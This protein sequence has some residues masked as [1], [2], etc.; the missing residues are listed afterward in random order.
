MVAAIGGLARRGILVRSGSILELAA[1]VDTVIFDKTG[2]VTEGQFEIIRIIAGT[3]PQ[4]AH[5]TR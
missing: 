2:T 3:H 5:P 4:S 1:K